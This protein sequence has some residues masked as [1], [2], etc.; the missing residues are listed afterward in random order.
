MGEPFRRDQARTIENAALL[1]TELAGAGYRIVSG[2]TDTHLF[3][4][5]VRGQKLTGRAAE[6]RLEKIGIALNKNTIPFDPEKPMVC[7]GIRI[8]TP[9]VTTRGMGPQ[10]MKTI[11]RLLVEA[12]VGEPD[13]AREADLA[14]RVRRLC[15]DFPLYPWLR[16]AASEAA[17]ASHR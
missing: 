4:V 15:G 3:L 9:A 1:A 11:A 17:G 13:A 2:G 7:S 16:S 6:Q 10:Q 14:Q 12:L 5:D 8:G